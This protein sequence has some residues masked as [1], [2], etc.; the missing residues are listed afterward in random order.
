MKS[1]DL[2]IIGGGPAGLTAGLYGSRAGMKTAII[3]QGAPGGQAI[4]TAHIENYPGYPQGIGG[5]ELMLSFWEQAMAFGVEFINEKVVSVTEDGDYKKIV[6]AEEEYETKA[7]VIATGSQYRLMGIPGE[8]ELTGHGVSYCAICDGAF[9]RDQKIL[10]VGGGDA[11]VEE[12]AFLTQFSPHV[13]LCHRGD[14]L[15]ATAILQKRLAESPVQV[16]MNTKLLE[17]AGGKRWKK[18]CCK[19]E[20][21]RLFGRTLL[22]CLSLLAHCRTQAF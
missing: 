19:P 4:L 9:Y 20:K 5:P 7:M 12:A 15:S 6:T 21:R 16:M 11:A 2:M 8:K 3:E 22:R 14:K 1:Y 17:V 10:V 13:Y 18:C